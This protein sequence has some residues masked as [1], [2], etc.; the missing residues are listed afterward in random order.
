LYNKTKST[1]N[2]IQHDRVINPLDTDDIILE[3]T[4]CGHNREEGYTMDSAKYHVNSHVIFN[5]KWQSL[6]LDRNWSKIPLNYELSKVK[7][8][9]SNIMY[10]YF[11]K[12][13]NTLREQNFIYNFN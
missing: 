3:N 4:I 7:P 2:D 13:I 1:I 5:F 12:D 9:L 11:E 10:P 6:P 8:N